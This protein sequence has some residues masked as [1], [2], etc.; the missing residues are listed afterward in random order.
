MSGKTEPDFYDWDDLRQRVISLEG[1]L[2]NEDT[3]D[4][5]EKIEELVT[6]VDTFE[7]MLDTL[8]YNT[9]RN[10]DE[11]NECLEQL[12]LVPTYRL[13]NFRWNREVRK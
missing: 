10:F 9:Q 12:D 2:R 11:L 5:E 6:R 7:E 13:P 4:I 3:K 1:A 8:E